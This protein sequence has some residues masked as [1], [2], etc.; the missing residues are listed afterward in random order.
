MGFGA[1]CPLPFRLGGT[2]EEGL[3]AA[4][5]ARLCA[6]LVAV[7]R[8]LPLAV[9]TFTPIA[10][11]VIIHDYTGLNGIGSAFAPTPTWINTGQVGFNW[12]SHS[13]E[14]PYEIVHQY[15]LRHG[16]ATVHSNA[17]EYGEVIIAGGTYQF[18]VHTRTHASAYVDRKTTAVLY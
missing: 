16:H 6:D 11:N 14:D 5:H 15:A 1:F 8:T 3:T 10:G 2:S 7:K 17:G 9:I 18:Q 13:F 12:A 4:Q